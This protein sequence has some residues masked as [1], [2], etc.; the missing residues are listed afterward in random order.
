M[1]YNTGA[2]TEPWGTPAAIFLGEES[3]PS[4]ETLN[5]LLLRNEAISFIKLAE[6]VNSNSLYSRPGCHVVSKA[7]WI[8]KNTATVDIL[9]LKLRVT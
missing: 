3:S 5:F 8:S 1:L 7:F 4:T 2:R 9:L 6:N